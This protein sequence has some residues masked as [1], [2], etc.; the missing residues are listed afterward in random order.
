VRGFLIVICMMVVVIII[1][2]T[3][4]AIYGDQACPSSHDV[5]RIDNKAYCLMRVSR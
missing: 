4:H 3:A 1:G 5:V 2:M